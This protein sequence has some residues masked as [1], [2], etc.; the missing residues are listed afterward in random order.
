MADARPRSLRGRRHTDTATTSTSGMAAVAFTSMASASTAVA[1]ASRPDEDE[2]APASSVS[3]TATA[4]PTSRSLCPPPTPW[5]NTIGFHATRAVANAARAGH[6]R[7]DSR[8]TRRI[9]ATAAAPA[10]A[11]YAQ[12][13]ATGPSSHRVRSEERRLKPGPYTAVVACHCGPTSRYIGSLAKSLGVAT[14]GLA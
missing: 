5:N 1:P 11:L 14:Y 2:R 10:I 13:R 12:I 9:V 3:A 4:S 7:L 8:A 6:S